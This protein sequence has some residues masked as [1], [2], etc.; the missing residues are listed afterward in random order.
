MFETFETV[1][2]V[3][4]R[5]VSGDISVVGIVEVLKEAG[6]DGLNTENTVV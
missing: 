1:F 3:E 4:L 6:S 5:I 2:E